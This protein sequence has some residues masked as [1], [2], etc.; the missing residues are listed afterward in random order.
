MR[1]TNSL[2]AK[3]R[4]Q[5][6]SA[7]G[8]APKKRNHR[9]ILSLTAAETP[10]SNRR[11]VVVCLLLLLATIS[12]Y[13]SLVGHSFLNYDD[14][15]YVSENPHVQSGIGLRS[16]QWMLTSFYAS[17][18]HPLTWLSH[19]VDLEL[20]G[21]N[22][23]GHHI[24]SLL[25]HAFNAVLLFWFLQS[26]TGAIAR[27]TFVAGL[28]ALHPLNVESVA[29]IAERKTVLSTFFFLL[30]LQAY[31]WY[32]ERAS[33]KRY[34]IVL[35]VFLL[36]LSSKPMVI[37]LPFVLLL[38]DYWPLCRIQGWT[39]S[40]IAFPTPQM[41]RLHLIKEKLPL[42]VLSLGSAL[43]TI[44]AQKAGNSVE[45][46]GYLPILWRVQNALYSY[47]MYVA[48]LFWPEN[49]AVFYPHPLNTLTALQITLSALLLAAISVIVWTQRTKRGYALTGW[50]WF[51]GTLVP[52]IGIVQVGA[53]GMADRYAYIPAIG[54]FLIFSWG[55]AELLASV[56]VSSNYRTLL[57]LILLCGLST[58]TV[59]QLVYW[60][61]PYDLWKHALDITEN[62]YVADD[63][64]A[65]VLVHQGRPEALRYY[66][67]AATIA[68]RD[69]I[70][71]NA[72][73]GSLQDRGKLSEAIQ[74]YAIA[75]K[76][77]P[78][79]R[80]AA[81]IY[82]ELGLIYRELGDY[83]SA[84]QNSRLSLLADPEE[85]TQMIS[86]L[87]SRLQERPAADGYLRLGSLLED[88]NRVADAKAAYERAL[89]LRPEFTPAQK[90][91]EAL[92]KNER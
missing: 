27:S 22:P 84:A 24:T 64:M 13:G 62:N 72:V 9:K 17:N 61:Q 33:W 83:S 71:H 39:P 20:Y 26:V 3:P 79:P 31:V 88:A 10:Q 69:P 15:Q 23:A 45:P 51:L 50:L 2:I 28:F 67:A 43:V 63:G 58:V 46:L 90:A 11:N 48:K 91:L 52:V 89:E 30:T 85:L 81:H 12:V 92:R 16:L 4:R 35:F 74:E 57:A 65:Y 86:Q 34:G 56:P 80:L 5:Y 8:R 87:S 68:P 54:I 55:A 29:W 66:E 21:P 25:I 49:L 37:S 36:G 76:A 7:A 41:P 53:Q 82:A 32:L 14:L 18:W 75:L 44:A 77:R 42:F 73:A 70:S 1:D 40:S 19:A 78:E 60:E 38:L 6:R 59:H 47:A